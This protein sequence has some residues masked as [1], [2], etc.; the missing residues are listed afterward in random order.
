MF[1]QHLEEHHLD[2]MYEDMTKEQ[3]HLMNQM[4]TRTSE[5]EQSDLMKQLT[6]VNSLTM[7]LLRLINLQRKCTLKRNL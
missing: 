3:S 4:K 1:R 5:E 7:N 6:L 2:K